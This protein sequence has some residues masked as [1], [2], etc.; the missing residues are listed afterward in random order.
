MQAYGG[1]IQ[2]VDDYDELMDQW[3]DLLEAGEYGA[4]LSLLE[5]RLPVLEDIPPL[6]ELLTRV[7]RRVCK[8]LYA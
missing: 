7:R 1:A 6:E 2:S 8:L 5:K 4:V 3:G